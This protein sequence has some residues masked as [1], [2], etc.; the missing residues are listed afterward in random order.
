MSDSNG[1][2][3]SAS[4]TTGHAIHHPIVVAARSS[5]L[6]VWGRPAAV[7]TTFWHQDDAIL[8]EARPAHHGKNESTSSILAS[9]T[10]TLQSSDGR[11]Q[12]VTTAFLIHS[13][14]Y[15]LAE[16]YGASSLQDFALQQLRAALKT[17]ELEVRV[18]HISSLVGLIQ[19]VYSTPLGNDGEPG[20]KARARPRQ[21]VVGQAVNHLSDL[22]TNEPFR[23]LLSHAGDSVG[24]LLA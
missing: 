16:R 1:D 4:C 6:G 13:K 8:E 3:E 21:I 18:D 20:F 11:G 22:Q 2:D 9:S 5:T 24:D 10:V 14:V 17:L 15:P 7:H 23:A 12:D 19:S